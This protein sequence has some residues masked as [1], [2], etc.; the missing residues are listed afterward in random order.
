M[1]AY[2][3]I[4]HLFALL[5]ELNV[6]VHHGAEFRNGIRDA[7]DALVLLELGDL[8]ADKQKALEHR[9]SPVGPNPVLDANTVVRLNQT[10][11]VTHN[12]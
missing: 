11:T 1:Y 4:F 3:N 12:M 8:R 6:G 7:R 9:N 2:V 5:L 10:H